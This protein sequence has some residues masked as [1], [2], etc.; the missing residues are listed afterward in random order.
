MCAAAV[1]IQNCSGTVA[2]LATGCHMLLY[3]M[4]TITKG[5]NT[6]YTVNLGLATNTKVSPVTHHYTTVD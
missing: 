1:R 3:A 4:H 5:N 2:L 6:G